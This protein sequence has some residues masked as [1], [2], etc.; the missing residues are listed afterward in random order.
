MFYYVFSFIK[1]LVLIADFA[2]FTLLL[3]MLAFL[4]KSILNTFYHKL[5]RLWSRSF[6]RAIGV[7]LKLHQKNRNPLP[8]QFLLI[9]NHPSAF[10]DIGVPAL[11][12]V[13][14][15]AKIE[16]KDWFI[17]GKI[18]EAAG[19]LYVHRESKESRGAAAEEIAN[20]LNSGKNIALYP[21]GGCKGR[22]IFETFFYGAFDISI[23][24]GVP[25]LPVF[26]QYEAQEDFE[27]ASPHTLLHKIWHY[28]ITD[29]N[30]AN[31]YVF[32]ALNPADFE[33]KQEYMEYTHQ[34][35]L[36]WQAKYLD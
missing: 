25:I 31:Y 33:N 10:E 6:V 11:F 24:T 16:V 32:D 3:Y 14:S 5:F 8:E 36:K 15:L 1:K 27:W 12:N 17:V 34:L 30:R 29:N 2:I 20:Q 26:L 9:A 19:T 35:Y 23:K 28:L 4:P 22:R 13:Y 21:E 7:D 18:S